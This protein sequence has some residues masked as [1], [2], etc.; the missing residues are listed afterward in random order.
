MQADDGARSDFER[1]PV[2][3]NSS[4]SDRSIAIDHNTA[5]AV[6]VQLPAPGRAHSAEAN[7]P[8]HN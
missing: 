6:A 7:Q 3:N 4:A 2:G 1:A 8:K 5:T